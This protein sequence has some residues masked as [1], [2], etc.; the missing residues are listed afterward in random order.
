MSMTRRSFMKSAAA[1]LASAAI[2]QQSAM[3][4]GRALTSS[5]TSRYDE[6]MAMLNTMKRPIEYQAF[7]RKLNS[8]LA[9]DIAAGY[10]QSLQKAFCPPQHNLMLGRPH[11]PDSE[12]YDL[13]RVMRHLRPADKLQPLVREYAR[14]EFSEFVQLA[15]TYVF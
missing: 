11:D 2:T 7:Q 5:T 8:Y 12:P 13:F 15:K 10:I 6:L 1:A 14:A 3:A 9:D 4:F